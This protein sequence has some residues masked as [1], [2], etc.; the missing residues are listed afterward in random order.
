MN[1]QIVRYIVVFIAGCVVSAAGTIFTLKD[2]EYEWP[3]PEPVRYC[4]IDKDTLERWVSSGWDINTTMK[5]SNGRWHFIVL[6]QVLDLAHCT[7][8]DELAAYYM[9]NGGCLA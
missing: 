1:M 5:W 4:Q 3:T 7:F 2:S 8:D 9:E 6:S